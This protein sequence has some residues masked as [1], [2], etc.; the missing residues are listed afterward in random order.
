MQDM[1]GSELFPDKE[2]EK[3]FDAILNAVQDEIEAD[4]RN[5]TILNALRMKQFQFAY[6]CLRYITQEDET[7]SVTYK[8][9]EPFKTMGS[10]TVEGEESLEFYNSK[11]LARA[12]EFASNVEVYPL[13]NGCVRM[14]LTFHGLTKPIE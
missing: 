8:L 14:T 1:Y 7:I 12:I 11:Y 4:E 13:A 2:T 9:C 6:A 5:V 10:V 3:E